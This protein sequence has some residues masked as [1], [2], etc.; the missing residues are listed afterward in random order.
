M[1]YPSEDECTTLRTGSEL[2]TLV[3]RKRDRRRA[4]LPEPRPPRD[5]LDSVVLE[6]VTLVMRREPEEE[7][8]A[9]GPRPRRR[10]WPSLPAPAWVGLALVF[11]LALAYG[12]GGARATAS[13]AMAGITPRWSSPAAAG[14]SHSTAALDAVDR[15]AAT[16]QPAHLVL[17]FHATEQVAPLYRRAL[18]DRVDGAELHIVNSPFGVR[19]RAYR[20]LMAY[21]GVRYR[22]SYLDGVA[23]HVGAKPLAHYDT[24]TVASFSAG[25]AAVRELL[26][27]PESAELIDAVVAIDSWHTELDREGRPRSD[28][29]Q[30]LARFAQRAARGPELCWI[31]HSDVKVDRRTAHPFASTT[32]VAHELRRL[33]G[34]PSGP[35]DGWQGGL[36]ISAVDLRADDHAEH[37]AA[38]TVWGDDWLADAVAA[39]LERRT[40]L[41]G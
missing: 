31:R 25:Y 9:L 24:I 8:V 27:E 37:V 13:T 11:V 36:R 33:A 23:W 19:A 6:T 1:S 12:L 15:S 17:L 32:E 26:G 38:L 20:H 4:A 21:I 30:S 39:L 7:T 3:Y 16:R 41:G 29:L 35:G 5:S 18:Q 14:P 22:S 10:R 2:D 40:K 28:Q 34:L